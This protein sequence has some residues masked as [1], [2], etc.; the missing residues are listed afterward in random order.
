[1]I[2]VAFECVGQDSSVTR[3]RNSTWNSWSKA[4]IGR[5]FLTLQKDQGWISA[6]WIYPPSFF[7]PMVKT[8]SHAPV[9]PISPSKLDWETRT[10]QQTKQ[11]AFTHASI[12]MKSMHACGVGGACVS[13]CLCLNYA[14]PSRTHSKQAILDA[15]REQVQGENHFPFTGLQEKRSRRTPGDSPA[16][17]GLCRCILFYWPTYSLLPAISL[18]TIASNSR[19]LDV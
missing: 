9:L 8:L 16:T 1:M 18:S 14:H 5:R 10:K 4:G 13:I 17:T 6:S 3:N 2:Q 11:H 15:S 12:C 19:M 7:S